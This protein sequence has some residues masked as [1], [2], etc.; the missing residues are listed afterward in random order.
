M[1]HL[2]IED[3]AAEEV[4]DS[5]FL[6]LLYENPD[7]SI[8]ACIFEHDDYPVETNDEYYLA[9]NLIRESEHALIFIHHHTFFLKG[10]IN[11]NWI[12]LNTGSSIDVFCNPGLLE[13]I[14]R[15]EQIKIYISI[16]QFFMSHTRA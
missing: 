4:P 5:H 1:I 3:N 16:L 15:L 9:Y 2:N 8:E 7:I 14:H 6:K 11:P 10:S 12:L 13:S